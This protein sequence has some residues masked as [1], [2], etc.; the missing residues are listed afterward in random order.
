M[1]PTLAH[2]PPR[3]HTFLLSLWAE[4]GSRPD[5][6]YSLEDPHTGA[7]TG[8]KTVDELAAFLKEWAQK[9]QPETTDGE[10]SFPD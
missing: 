3:Y 9:P 4:S 1:P 8:F 2:R 6:R 10:M 7:R 5:W